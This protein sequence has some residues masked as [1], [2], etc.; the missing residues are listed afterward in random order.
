[1]FKT[2]LSFLTETLQKNLDQK[3]DPGF[4]VRGPEEQHAQ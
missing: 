2:Q 4:S 1:M 3:S